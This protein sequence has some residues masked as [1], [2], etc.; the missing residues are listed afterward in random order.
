MFVEKTGGKYGCTRK[1]NPL[2]H[3]YEE[4]RSTYR[5]V[6]QAGESSTNLVFTF[7]AC[8]GLLQ[9]VKNST[10]TNIVDTLA[11]CHTGS[12]LS[13]I[14]EKIKTQ[15]GTEGSNLTMSVA[16]NKRTKDRTSE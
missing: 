8:S 3:R 14:D 2:L 1:H 15:L 5:S 12:T 10:K 11:I 6:G 16:G 13:F 7:T 9:A 4:T